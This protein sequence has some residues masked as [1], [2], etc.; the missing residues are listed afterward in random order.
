MQDFTLQHANTFF[1]ITTIAVAILV[2]ILLVLLYIAYKIFVFIKRTIVRMDTLLDSAT[3]HTETNPIYKKSLP[4][5]LP[6][7]GYM[8]GKKRKVSKK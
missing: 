1:F 7:L 5:I 3:E 8:F 2:V 6:I 4:Y